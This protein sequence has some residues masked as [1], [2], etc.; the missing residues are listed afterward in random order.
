MTGHYYY[1][2]VARD[3]GK[4]RKTDYN[5]VS[6]KLTTLRQ[7]LIFAKKITTH[8]RSSLSW[9]GRDWMTWKGAVKLA[10]NSFLA[11]DRRINWQLLVGCNIFP[12]R[13]ADDE[14]RNG[15]PAWGAM[16]DSRRWRVLQ[17]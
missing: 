10:F 12:F 4:T 16:T 11:L 6:L 3:G 1:G 15:T 9:A 7:Y 5:S 8:E 17:N 13:R 2:K 14:E